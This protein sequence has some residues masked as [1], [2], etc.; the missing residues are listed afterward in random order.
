MGT[1]TAAGASPGRGFAS[2]PGTRWAP[3]KR[4]PS[5]LFT[6]STAVSASGAWASRSGM[7]STASVSQ[8]TT[9]EE[10]ELT[11]QAFAMVYYTAIIV[12][13]T[14]KGAVIFCV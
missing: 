12:D 14:A 9:S 1:P 3:P 13:F 2:G 4:H 10:V 7:W 6:T 8:G 5:S 11:R